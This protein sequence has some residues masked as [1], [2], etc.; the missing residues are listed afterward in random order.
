[1]HTGN[2]EGF[3]IEVT[4]EMEHEEPEGYIDSG[5]KEADREVIR[6]IRN[7]D[8]RWFSAKVTASKAGVELAESHLGG[9]CYTC[10]ADFVDNSGY[11]EDMRGEVVAAA[12]KK[13]EQLT[14]KGA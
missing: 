3:D 7:G 14:A 5:D 6:R 9:C 8:Y 12:I 2:F 1:M 4:A 10:L 11:Y 13:I